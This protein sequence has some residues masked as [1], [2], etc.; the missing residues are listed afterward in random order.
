MKKYVVIILF[1]F[2][3]QGVGFCQLSDIKEDAETEE[4]EREREQERSDRSNSYSN[5][6]ISVGGDIL[7]AFLEGVLYVITES[8]EP[9]QESALASAADYP[10]RISLTVPMGYGLDFEKSTDVIR[11]S[12][13]GSYGIIGTTFDYFSLKDLQDRLNYF[14]WLFDFK[15]PIKSVTINYGLGLSYLSSVRTT[16]FASGLGLDWKIKDDIFL[17]GDYTWTQR[18]SSGRRF[19]ESASARIEKLFI[20]NDKFHF[21]PFLMYSHESYFSRTKFSFTSLGLVMRMF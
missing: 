4:R 20:H 8:L 1:S 10:E 6:D 14:T 16:Y 11:G 9:A 19:K 15:I 18:L 3:I 13:E 7:L 12:F 17:S 5:D 21:G 2:F